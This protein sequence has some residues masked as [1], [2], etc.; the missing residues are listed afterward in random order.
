MWHLIYDAIKVAAMLACIYIAV[1][2]AFDDPK[3]RLN[4]K[5]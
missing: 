4:K 5:K 2:S 1:A 3:I